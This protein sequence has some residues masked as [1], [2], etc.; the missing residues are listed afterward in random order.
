MSRSSGKY[1]R[2]MMGRRVARR[3]FD[4]GHGAATP[5]GRLLD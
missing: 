2:A 4:G 3:I 1:W 5:V